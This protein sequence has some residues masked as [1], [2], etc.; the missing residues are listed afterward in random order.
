MKNRTRQSF[1]RGWHPLRQLRVW[2]SLRYLISFVVYV[3][4]FK[5]KNVCYALR[6]GSGVEFLCL[7]RSGVLMFGKSCVGLLFILTFLHSPLCVPPPHLHPLVPLS[8][9]SLFTPSTS[10]CLRVILPRTFSQQKHKSKLV[11]SSLF[12]SLLFNFQVLRF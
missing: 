12:L 1:F 4:R 3:C 2:N 7:R 6:D 8:I 11:I 9:F 10:S 5:R